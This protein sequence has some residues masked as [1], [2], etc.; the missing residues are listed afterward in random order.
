M[1][2]GISLLPSLS[3]MEHVRISIRI[4]S[5]T[6]DDAITEKNTYHIKEFEWLDFSQR[7]SSEFINH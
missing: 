2:L 3:R 1:N 4:N 7:V 6:K 5:L